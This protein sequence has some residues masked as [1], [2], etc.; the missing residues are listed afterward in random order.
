MHFAYAVLGALLQKTQA[1]QSYQG[2]L[3]GGW[4][5]STQ[6]WKGT[7]KSQ[8]VLLM[9]NYNFLGLSNK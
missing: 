1:T 2:V 4:S 5:N 8:E 3:M 6:D 7:S 9:E